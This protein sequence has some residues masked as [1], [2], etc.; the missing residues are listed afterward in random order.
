[1]IAI[2][3]FSFKPYQQLSSGSSSTDE[4]GGGQIRTSV[5]PST[6]TLPWA[7]GHCEL[8]AGSDHLEL[9][10]NQIYAVAR[11]PPRQWWRHRWP[12]PCA[13][14]MKATTTSVTAPSPC[15]GKRIFY[16]FLC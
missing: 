9:E 16:G 14:M 13:T 3:L 8:E 11:K 1:M 7:A 4:L 15:S 12:D 10:G 6:S 5:A 2:Q